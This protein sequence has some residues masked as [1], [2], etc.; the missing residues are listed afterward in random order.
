MSMKMKTGIAIAAAVGAATGL[1][2]TILMKKRKVMRFCCDTED[3]DVYN[4]EFCDCCCDDGSDLDIAIPSE[5]IDD[6][7]ADLASFE[8]YDGVTEDFEKESDDE[9]N[10]G[11]ESGE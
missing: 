7:D 3:Y 5:E 8:E 2:V 10:E 11:R 1:A 4:D 9:S 6:A